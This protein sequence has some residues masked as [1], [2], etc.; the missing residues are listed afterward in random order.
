MKF[1][2]GCTALRHF[3]IDGSGRISAGKGDPEFAAFV[4]HYL[5]IEPDVAMTDLISQVLAEAESIA[6]MFFGDL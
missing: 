1:F 6:A 3:R 5:G 4:R 2:P